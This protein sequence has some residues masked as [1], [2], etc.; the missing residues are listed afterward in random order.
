MAE[1]SMVRVGGGFRSGQY[2][3][4]PREVHGAAKWLRGL[5]PIAFTYLDEG[6]PMSRDKT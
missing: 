4:I 6:H 3:L 2:Q 5:A 1:G